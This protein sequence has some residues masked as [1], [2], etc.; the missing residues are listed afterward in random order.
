MN[1]YCQAA[2]VIPYFNEERLIHSCLSHIIKAIRQLKSTKLVEIVLVD[3]NS[4]DNTKEAISKVKQKNDD[5]YLHVI[6]EPK[7][8]QGYARQTGVHFVLTRETR[9]ATYE[10]NN[11][12]IINTDADILVPKQWLVKWFKFFCNPTSLISTGDSKFGFNFERRYP[13][14]AQILSK[15]SSNISIAEKLFGVINVDGFN[16]VIEKKCYQAIGPFYQPTRKLPKGKTVNLAG[17]DWDLGTRAKALQ[18]FPSRIRNN[19]VISSPR[20]FEI[21]P[22]DFID[23]TTYEGPFEPIKQTKPKPDINQNQVQ[24]LSRIASL[25]VCVHYVEKPILVNPKLLLNPLVNLKL[26]TPLIKDMQNW[27]KNTTKPN[28]FTQRNKFF[29]DYLHSFHCQFGNRLNNLLFAYNTYE[30]A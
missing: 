18:I 10:S 11:F 2:I 15:T 27:I 5:I 17:E 26:T 4:T 19:H 16:S 23:G 7:K 12:W 9:R 6:S 30:E 3:N 24:S 1:P 14:F 8:G 29:I 22:K 13:N 20:R 25:R 21:S 28:L